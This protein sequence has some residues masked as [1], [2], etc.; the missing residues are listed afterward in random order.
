MP[1]K[2]VKVKAC[3]TTIKNKVCVLILKKDL[4]PKGTSKIFTN[5]DAEVNESLKKSLIENLSMH[6]GF[7]QQSLNFHFRNDDNPVIN[8]FVNMVTSALT[9]SRVRIQNVTDFTL[10]KNNRLNLDFE[11]FQVRPAIFEVLHMLRIH[12]FFTK[13]IEVIVKISDAVPMIARAD[14]SRLQQ[15]ISCFAWNAFKFSTDRPIH[16]EITAD[17][18]HLIVLVVDEGAGMSQPILDKVCSS[19][20]VYSDKQELKLSLYTCLSLIDSIGGNTFVNSRQ[21]KGTSVKLMIP[22]MFQQMPER[23]VM[24]PQ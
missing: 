24:V 19:K 22:C 20:F 4:M 3:K 14:R 10:I 6:V 13:R 11:I 15:L 16:I 12:A 17:P 18:K 7:V 2:L 21:G 5:E 1:D 9:N 23:P 8:E